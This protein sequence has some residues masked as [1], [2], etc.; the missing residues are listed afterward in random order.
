MVVEKLFAQTRPLC[1]SPSPA[2]HTSVHARR[3][4]TTIS[5]LY[6]TVLCYYEQTSNTNEK[7]TLPLDFYTSC[8]FWSEFR[9]F[10]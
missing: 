3:K 7:D 5:V 10:H 4:Y 1:P 6:I 8:F 2:P 9:A